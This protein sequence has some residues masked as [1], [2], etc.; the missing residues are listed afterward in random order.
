MK[1]LAEHLQLCVVDDFLPPVSQNRFLQLLLK[2]RACKLLGSEGWWSF[3]SAIAFMLF[4]PSGLRFTVI[5]VITQKPPVPLC[6][7][8]YT[9]PPLGL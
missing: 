8:N 4:K 7:N 6:Y 2:I 9:W 5:Y 1:D 3:F